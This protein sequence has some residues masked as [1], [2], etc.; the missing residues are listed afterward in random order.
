MTG[1]IVKATG[2]FYYVKLQDR[3][4]E[5]RARGIFRRHGMSPCV[6]DIVDISISGEDGSGSVDTIHNRKNEL[7]RPPL[8]NLDY[9]LL[10]ISATDPSPNFLVIDKLLAVLEHKAI[11]AIIAI[12]K[13][14]LHDTEEIAATYRSA[15]YEVYIVNNTTGEGAESLA[16]R[17]AEQFVALSGNSGVG[18]SSLLNVI[19][20]TLALAV[21]DTS[22][23]LGRGRHTTRHVEIFET[24]NGAM[25]ADTPGFS[26]LDLVMMSKLKAD[27]LADCF[28]EFADYM[29]NCR[30]QD[31]R[32]LVERDC[33]VLAAVKDGYI[34]N[35]RHR[36]YTLLYDEIKDV[37]EWN[38]R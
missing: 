7:V 35:S 19:D 25:V 29:H 32:H 21:G 13:P 27:E 12:T 23:K 28:P 17:M 31:C 18:K 11:P 22:R 30:F 3:I 4:A 10:I 34:S 6:G 26:S 8:A 1:R 2:G 16:A 33:A 36:S 14:D 15:G 5:C 24:P 9:M 20:P 38:R 37:K